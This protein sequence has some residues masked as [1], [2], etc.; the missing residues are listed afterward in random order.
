MN[1]S[2]ES[3]GMGRGVQLQEI[4]EKGGHLKGVRIELGHAR[5]STPHRANGK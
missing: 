1:S 4:G 2:T 3:R 5:P